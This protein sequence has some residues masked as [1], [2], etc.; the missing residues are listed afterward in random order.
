MF[1]KKFLTYLGVLTAILSLVG[2]IWAFDSHY[3]T[4][5][6]VTEVKVEAK[7]K[8]EKLEIQ[9]AGALQNQQ[10]K[11]DVK[12]YQFMYDKLTQEKNAI[13]RELRKNPNDAD[14]QRDYQEIIEDMKRTKQ[15]MNE[16]LR[17]IN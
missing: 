1:T 10:Q 12:F 13:R 7:E 4:D 6:R 8:V 17:K 15:Q 16:A 14:L 3:A 5:E 2:G 9:I 11:S